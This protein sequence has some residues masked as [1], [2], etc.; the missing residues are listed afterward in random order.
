MNETQ[1]QS[2]WRSLAVKLAVL[3][4]VWMLL[5]T[6]FAAQF[7]WL[8]RDWPFRISW[9]DAFLH[10]F[11]E[12]C[13]WLVLSPL[14]VWLAERFRFERERWRWGVLPH[15]LGSVLVVLAYQGISMLLTERQTG[16]FFQSDSG[17]LR[18]VKRNSG[19]VEGF[20]SGAGAPGPIPPH[21]IFLSPHGVG[22]VEAPVSGVSV[23]AGQGPVSVHV[24]NV[25]SPIPPGTP[26]TNRVQLVTRHLPFSGDFPPPI[27]TMPGPWV[28]FLQIAAARAQFTIPVYWAIVCVTWVISYYQQLRER[29]RRTLELEARLTQA[30]LQT[31]KSQLQPHFLFNTLNAIASLVRRKPEAAENMIGSLS[32]FL[33][34][35]LDAA[36]QHEVPLRREIEFLDHYL[37]IQQTRFG[38]RLR[39]EK[40]IEPAALDVAVP[41]LILQPLVENSLRHGLEQR[42]SGGTILIRASRDRDSLRLQVRDDGEGFK[43][44]QLTAIC[45]GIGLSNTKARLQE[46]Y[47]DAHRFQITSNADGGLTVSVELPWRGSPSASD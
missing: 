11:M 31:L 25:P 43:G 2:A 3:G 26:P 39:I 44:G 42:E 4:L 27:P 34:M 22:P 21:E 18:V 28:R 35:N 9:K 7:F 33:R 15:L 19:V 32:D 13:P 20:A 16:V 45:E 17:N 6:A 30:N 12:W 47:G 14:V 38:E 29:E 8:A 46:L 1:K 36:Q 24:I 37:D 41:T 23:S 40:E 5:A 10:S